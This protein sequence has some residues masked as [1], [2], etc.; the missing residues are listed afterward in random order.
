[1]TARERYETKMD[2]TTPA[3]PRGDCH[4]WL[5][6]LDTHGYGQFWLEG[7]NRVAS[8]VAWFFAHGEWAPAELQVLHTCDMRRCVN[9][10]HLFLGTQ[11]DN[12]KD[13][14]SKGRQARGER[15]GRAGLTESD[16]ARIRLL[17]GTESQEITARRFGIHQTNVSSIQRGR[18]WSMS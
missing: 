18:T 14:L 4:L 10:A 8:H 2:R 1:M 15:S 5:R 17:R 13:M 3:G 6:G 16:I 9:P 12:F 7:R 11:A